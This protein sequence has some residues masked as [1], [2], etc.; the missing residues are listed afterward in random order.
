MPDR[1]HYEL[2]EFVR[3]RARR[4][5]RTAV[6]Y[7]ADDWEIIY[8]RDDLP[9][10]PPEHRTATI[11]KGVREREPLRQPGNPL[12]DFQSVVELYEHGVVVVVAESATAGVVLSLEREAASD[13]AG[14]VV[15]CERLVDPDETSD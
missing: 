10:D 2:V 15:E 3:S 6:H 9:D 11:V 13:L 5:F 14:F 1:R 12:G 7:T 8:R 4:L